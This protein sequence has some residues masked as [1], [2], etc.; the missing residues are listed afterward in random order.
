MKKDNL[1]FLVA[2]LLVCVAI[3]I[4]LVI[5]ISSTQND[6]AILKTNVRDIQY[7]LD[8]IEVM[9]TYPYDHSKIDTVYEVK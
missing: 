5:M 3:M 6:V 9:Q 2:P 4:I 1:D 7:K 8:S